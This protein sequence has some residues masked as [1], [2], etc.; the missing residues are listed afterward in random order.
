MT[1]SQAGINL[2]N[3]MLMDKDAFK[4]QLI[5]SFQNRSQDHL[6]KFIEG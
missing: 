3:T 5:L 2:L 4:N 1:G 6:H